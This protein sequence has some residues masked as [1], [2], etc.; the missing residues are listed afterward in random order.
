MAPKYR[1]KKNENTKPETS[2]KSK[3]KLKQK[4]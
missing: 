4:L 1:E 2:I 3:L